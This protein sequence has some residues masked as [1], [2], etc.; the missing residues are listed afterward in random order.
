MARWAYRYASVVQ[1]HTE[2]RDKTSRVF[3]SYIC[4]LLNYG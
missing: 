4:V 1:Q 3:L 2:T